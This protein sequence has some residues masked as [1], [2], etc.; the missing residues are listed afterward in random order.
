MDPDKDDT[1]PSDP[2]E[3]K[4]PKEEPTEH[5]EP[6]PAEAEGDYYLEAL[7]QIGETEETG[8]E[9][10]AEVAGKDLKNKALHAKILLQQTCGSLL[11]RPGAVVDLF[12]VGWRCWFLFLKTLETALSVSPRSSPYALDLLCSLKNLSLPQSRE[13]ARRRVVDNYA[14]YSG[15]YFWVLRTIVC[16]C[17]C[18]F[19]SPWRVGL[20]LVFLAV[21]GFLPLEDRRVGPYVMQRDLQRVFLVMVAVCSSG[22]MD[23]VSWCLL[24]ACPAII[25]HLFLHNSALTPHYPLFSNLLRS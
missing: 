15:E 11:N 13:E 23:V 12:I 2:A 3:P 22:V 17:V 14:S 18:R 19:A 5:R 1:K 7:N 21:C 9:S 4:D 10:E 24:L 16:F 20:A 8:S 25:L 6:H